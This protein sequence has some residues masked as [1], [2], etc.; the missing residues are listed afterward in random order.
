SPEQ[1]DP[2]CRDIDTRSDIYSLG[3]LLYELL[4]SHTPFDPKLMVLD[5]LSSI[6]QTICELEPGRPS[7]RLSNLESEARAITGRKHVTQLEHLFRQIRGDLDCIVMKCL[8]KDRTCRYGTANGLAMDIKRHLNNELVLARPPSAPHA[9]KKF[10]IRH[11][12]PVILN[13][14]V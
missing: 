7:T 4:T 2:E 11:K 3:V 5:G 10:I 6:R 13:A 8:E 1:A 14:T 9:L 12:W